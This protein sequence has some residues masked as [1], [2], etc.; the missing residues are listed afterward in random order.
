MNKF[1]IALLFITSVCNVHASSGLKAD[2]VWSFDLKRVDPENKSVFWGPMLSFVLPGVNQWWEDQWS[3]GALYSGLGLIG[4]E[5]VRGA[6][7]SQDELKEIEKDGFNDSENDKFRQYKL[8]NQIY[9]AAGSFSAYASFQSSVKY[10]KE[11][12]G[13]YEFIKK[14]ETV[15]EILL[16]PFDFSFLKRKTTYFP[17]LLIGS[18]M[19]A[20]EGASL[21]N[22]QGAD[23]FYT[24]AYSYGAGTNE[25]ALFRGWLMP[26]FH[27]QFQSPLWANATT[28]VLFAAAHGFSPAPLP[29]LAMGY[30]LGWVTQKNDY[31]IREAVF[32]HA[33][34]DIFAIA[35]SYMDGD[36]GNDGMLYMP[37]YVG[38]F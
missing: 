8:G 22:F 37:L 38:A 5:T 2:E 9:M 23:A 33:W 30:Y 3:Q 21:G 34:W 12:L 18:L 25:E 6:N 7:L 17:L 10:R 24:S 13:E 36:S 32:I 28:S 31:S 16:A 26:M 1:L 27:Q 4:I 29:Q 14:Q 15:K 20:G 19:A 11:M 35:S